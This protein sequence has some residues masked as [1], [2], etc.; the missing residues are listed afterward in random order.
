M[1]KREKP[2]PITLKEGLTYWQFYHM[3]M[4]IFQGLFF[5]SH[6]VSVYKFAADDVIDDLS[7]SIAGALLGFRGGLLNRSCALGSYKTTGAP[8][9]RT[10][11][12]GIYLTT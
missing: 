8:K 9:P 2:A 5:G 4:M 7:L 6:L 10:W 1:V 3:F 12:V 11:A